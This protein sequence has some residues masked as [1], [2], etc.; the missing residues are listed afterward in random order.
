VHIY[1]A[2]AAPRLLAGDD[3]L[4]IPDLFGDF[5]VRVDRFFE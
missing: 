1:R 3:E 2:D 4:N 5:H